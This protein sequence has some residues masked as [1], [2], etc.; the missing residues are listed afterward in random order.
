MA[1]ET[2]KLL[3]RF[4]D[5]LQTEENE[6]HWDFTVYSTYPTSTATTLSPGSTEEAFDKIV[7]DRFQAYIESNLRFTVEEPYEEEIPLGIEYIRLPSASIQDARAHFRAKYGW[8]EKHEGY[9][10]GGGTQEHRD[11][12]HAL[13]VVIDEET[14][15]TWN[16]AP[17][18]LVKVPRGSRYEDAEEIIDHYW[19]KTE[20]EDRIVVKVVDVDYDETCE[21]IQ[22]AAAG[23]GTKKDSPHSLT[24]YGY[25]KTTPRWLQKVWTMLVIEFDFQVMFKGKD[26]VYRG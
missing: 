23:R 4:I 7:C 6:G 16:E 3:Q 13:F 14:M 10:V 9:M 2:P 21:G 24:F 15:S 25:I 18:V 11:L 20:R 8:P 22:F 17:D 26:K 1:E 5:G 19:E 12:R